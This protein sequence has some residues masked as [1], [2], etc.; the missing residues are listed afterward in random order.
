MSRP[1]EG[2]SWRV[3]VDLSWPKGQNLSINSCVSTDS[4]LNKKFLLKFPTVDTIC[5][6][7]KQFNHSVLLFKIDLSRAFRQLPLDP[8]DAAFL[9]ISWG[10][11]TYL[12]NVLPFGWRHGSAA[13]QRVT[14]A[15]RYILKKHDIT[16]V[17]YID[18]FIGVAP[19]H[20]AHRA[21][22]MT[23]KI[24]A[25]I[26]L[27]I[28]EDKTVPPVSECVCLGIVIN[29]NNLAFPMQN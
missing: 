14:D 9:G 12:D 17:N 8:L 10:G 2:S 28:S 19:V 4:Y 7:I 29:T 20:D 11:K 25:D 26:G 13:S 16:V 23:K 3:I 24:L 1:K 6:V 5:N 18:D 27:V 15:V 22:Y 21:F